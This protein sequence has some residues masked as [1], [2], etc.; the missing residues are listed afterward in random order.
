MTNGSLDIAKERLRE[1]DKKEETVH[2]A[3]QKDKKEDMEE[4]YGKE[5]EHKSN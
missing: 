3:A 4:K 2:S 1:R 5:S